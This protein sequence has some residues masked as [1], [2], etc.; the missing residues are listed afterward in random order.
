M[1][2]Q[3][4]EKNKSNNKKVVIVFGATGGVG[5]NAAMDLYKHGFSVVAV[6]HRLSDNGFFAQYG[7]P[8]FSVDIAQ[9]EAYDVLPQSN[10]WGVVN[11][12]GAMPASMNEYRPQLYIDT[13]LTGTLN[14]LNYCLKAGANRIIFAQSISDAIHLY[15]TRTPIPADIDMKFPLNNDHSV[16]SICKNAAVNLMEHYYAKYGIKR[17]V[18]RFPN[19]YMYHPNKFYYLDGMKKWHASRYLMEKAIQGE[20]IELWG[21][22]N[23]VRDIV[24]VKDCVQI[25]RKSLEADVEGGVYNVGT[26]VGITLKEQLEGIIEV[27]SPVEHKSTIVMRPEM[28]DSPEY[29]MDISKTRLE[30]GYEPKYD[31]LAYLR[32]MKKEMAEQRFALLWGKEEK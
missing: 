17:F 3:V 31:Y 29:I 23:V 24:Y 11:M 1:I 15:G 32:D 9:P 20:T 18:L 2:Y 7:I 6:G 8:Y 4:E 19:I 5:A 13:I 26:G 25:I 12:A 28:P 21:N 16:Y 30:L 10:V 27:F 22:P 14:M